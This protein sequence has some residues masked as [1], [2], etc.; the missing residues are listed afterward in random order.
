MKVK[1]LCKCAKKRLLKVPEINTLLM[2][3]VE[4]RCTPLMW[5]GKKTGNHMQYASSLGQWMLCWETF[6]FAYGHNF[7][8][9]FNVYQEQTFL[10]LSIGD[11]G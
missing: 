9:A 7:G 2:L 11:E 5:A 1:L 3:S 4:C 6:S 8:T 10:S